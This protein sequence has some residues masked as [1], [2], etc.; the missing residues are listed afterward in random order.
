MENKVDNK[1][2]NVNH[3]EHYAEKCSLECIECM[4]LFLGEEGVQYFCL[5]NAFKYMWRYKYKNQEEDLKKAK[6]YLDNFNRS[7][8]MNELHSRL[9]RL[10]AK[11]YTR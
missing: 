7:V 10:L 2:D 1:V 6:W 5:G 8:K 9:C 4:E 3:P 11:L